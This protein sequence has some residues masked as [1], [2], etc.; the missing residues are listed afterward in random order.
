MKTREEQ[1]FDLVCAALS[2][3]CANSHPGVPASEYGKSA[4]S[5]ADAA[6]KEL[7]GEPQTQIQYGPSK[8]GGLFRGGVPDKDGWIPHRPGDPMPCDGELRVWFRCR[9]GY[10]SLR[11]AADM[12]P[13][14][15]VGQDWWTGAGA[16]SKDQII[17]W[18][19]AK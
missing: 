7:Y 13:A 16:Q 14:R 2:G 1:R 4:V 19:P 11:F 6:M 5:F 12:Q 9:D 10:E 3:L 8:I 15:N 17:A 18:K